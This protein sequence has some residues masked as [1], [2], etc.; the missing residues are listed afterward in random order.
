MKTQYILPAL[1]ALVVT[2][3]TTQAFAAGLTYDPYESYYHEFYGIGDKPTVIQ[4]KAQQ[5][6]VF[7]DP[8]ADYYNNYNGTY[9]QLNENTTDA[10]IKTDETVTSIDAEVMA[11][12]LNFYEW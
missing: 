12:P 5:E 4:D 3:T 6:P 10:T 2:S 11:D 7:Y 8:Y 9:S 1:L